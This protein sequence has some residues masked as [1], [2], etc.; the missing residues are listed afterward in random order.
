MTIQLKVTLDETKTPWQVE[1]DEKNNAN[2]VPRGSSSQTI[3][4]KLH[5]NAEGGTIAWVGWLNS[6]MPTDIFGTPTVIHQGKEMTVSDLNDDTASAGDWPYQLSVTLNGTT[7]YTP[8]DGDC[9]TTSN[10]IIKNR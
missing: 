6:N 4:W 2:H 9:G 1:V 7:Y 3:T 10:P 8:T 5:G